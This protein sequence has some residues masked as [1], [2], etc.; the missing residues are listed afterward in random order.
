MRYGHFDTENDEYVVDRPDAPV[1]FT[2]YLGSGDYCVVLGHNGGG[3][4]Y[5]RSPRERLS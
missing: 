2:N 4:S 3:Y 5:Y 1:S